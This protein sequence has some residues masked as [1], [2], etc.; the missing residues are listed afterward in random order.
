MKLSLS[1]FLYYSTQ[2][3]VRIK[4]VPLGVFRLL[5]TLGVLI[6][7]CYIIFTEKRYQKK[8]SIISSIH[9]KVKGFANVQS[10][11]W[12]TAEYTIPSPG[13]D[14]FFVLTNIVKTENQIQNN[15]PE[16]PNPKT[17]CS[18]DD[19]CQRDLAV[20]QSNGFQTGRCVAFN[21]TVRTCEV[22]AWCLWSQ[23]AT[24]GPAVL[25]SAENFTVLIKNNIH[26]AAFNYTKKNIPPQY[27]MSCIHER[28]KAPLCPIFRLGDIVREAGENFSQI[29]VLGAVIG[30]E[31]KWDCDLDFWR[32]KCLPQYSFRRLDD[33][34]VDG[35]LFL[36]LNFRFAR[37]YKHQDGT[38]TRTLIKAYGIRFDIQVHGTGR[39]IQ[40]VEL[41]ISIGSCLSYFGCAAVAIDLLLGLYNRRCCDPK[42]ALKYYDERKYEEIPGP[43]FSRWPLKFISFVDKDDILMVDKKA[44]GTGNLQSAPGKYIKRERFTYTESAPKRQDL[45]KTELIAR[46]MSTAIPPAWCNCLKCQE[47]SDCE[48]QLCCRLQT[49]DCITNSK[50]FKDLVLNKEALENI[51]LYENP[52]SE[53]PISRGDLIHYAKR[54]Y[55][56]WRFGS[57]CYALSFAVIPNCCKNAIESCGFN[58]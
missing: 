34:V 42:S 30:I 55:I 13:G 2:K 16:F 3:E 27:N 56:Q 32:Q 43:R 22:R 10:R 24:P 58:T 9:T 23:K 54:Q 7:I 52:L 33:K 40:M 18:R 41:I 26:F 14:S 31:I 35:N 19:V 12:D 5:I 45:T 39:S 57:N 36:G 48:E 11:I 20:P 46:G 8:D 44:M 21:Q 51:F 28:I 1:D 50:M 38:E 17:F 53:I 37:Y 49:G 25:Q 4:S 6:L 15:C 47:I 29:A